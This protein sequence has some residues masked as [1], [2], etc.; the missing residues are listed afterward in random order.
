[1]N[2]TGLEKSKRKFNLADVII[3]IAAAA[4]AAILLHLFLSDSGFFTNGTKT[5]LSYT[6]KIENLPKSF[7]GAVKVGDTVCDDSTA[8]II[9]IVEKIEYS[10][11]FIM[12][13]NPSLRYYEKLKYPDKETLTLTVNTTAFKKNGR[14][15]CGGF[16][17]AAG[18]S[19]VF[20]VPE[21]ISDAKIVSV[22]VIEI[23]SDEDVTIT[24]MSASARG[25]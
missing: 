8:T 6:V 18:E 5:E 17:V 21:L 22:S 23:I 10:D 24:N 9:G 19:F 14:Y 7:H 13:Y 16:T 3:I 1:M 11:S 20:R 12:N 2:N 15:Q 25:E 4:A